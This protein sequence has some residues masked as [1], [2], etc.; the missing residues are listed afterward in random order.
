VAARALTAYAEGAS[1]LP[2]VL[3]AR[4]NAREVLAQYIDNVAALLI[5]TTELHAL[6]QTVPTP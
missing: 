2:A 5:V 1:A 4:R 3:E 6:T